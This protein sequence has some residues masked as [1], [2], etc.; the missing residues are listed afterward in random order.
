M[1]SFIAPNLHSFAMR[2]GYA[3]A[4]LFGA[5]NTAN[6]CT[7]DQ[8]TL[9]DNSCVDVKFTLE[10]QGLNKNNNSFQISAAGVFYVDWGDGNV[11][12]VNRTNDTTN[13][14]VTHTYAS[15]GDRTIR[16]GGVAT[17]YN[18]SNTNIAAINFSTSTNIKKAL[19]RISGSLTDLFPELGTNPGQYPSFRN[20][21]NGC[22]KL[23]NIP[24]NIFRGIQH[25]PKDIF[26]STFYACSQLS[27][28][29][30]PSAFGGLIQN[31]SPYVNNLFHYTFNSTGLD[32]TCSSPHRLYT[33]GYESYWNSKVS[34]GTQYAL[35]YVMNG[36]TNY[37]GAPTTFWDDEATTI[38]GIPTKADNVF[39]GWCSDAGLTDCAMS[40]TIPIY[41]T[42]PQTIYAK[43]TPISGTMCSGGYYR[44]NGSCVPVGAGYWSA[45]NS[46]TRTQCP[47]G[48]T[49][50]GYGVGADQ[51]TDCGY[52]LHIGAN[53]IYLRQDRQTTRTLNVQI[54]NTI[55]YA[56][57]S[58]ANI[59]MSD[60]VDNY[61]KVNVGGT[62]YSVYDDSGEEYTNP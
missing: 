18:S 58:T 20:T 22:N 48:T 46:D 30:P 11:E 49:T 8:I 56:N 40:Y 43:F 47:A 6:A 36:G 12:V 57:M 15:K 25:A 34:C 55:Y 19:V 26:D 53:T 44:N 61:L 9:S 23:T 45:Y 29:I 54:G 60:N 59:K 31:G 52:E 5:I 3:V 38:N 37:A 33:T 17:A 35:T 2:T 7:A 41:T 42:T 32:T 10:F 24:E 28:F 14:S 1:H 4:L 50:I 21:F 13:A 16:I 27:G 62:V 39:S 51:A